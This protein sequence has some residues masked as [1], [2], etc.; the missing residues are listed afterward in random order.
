MPNVHLSLSKIYDK[1]YEF[2]VN[3]EMTLGSRKYTT[4][5]YV[6]VGFGEILP[7]EGL[8]K[9]KNDEFDSG[10]KGEMLQKKMP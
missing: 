7:M 4:C 10:F 2:D 6:G 9:R 3:T 1:R 8:H 5:E